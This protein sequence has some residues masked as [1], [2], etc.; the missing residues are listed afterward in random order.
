M[1][2]LYE[3]EEEQG[4]G[5]GGEG[6]GQEGRDGGAGSNRRNCL[7]VMVLTFSTDARRFVSGAGGCAHGAVGWV[8]PGGARWQDAPLWPGGWTGV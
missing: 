6:P 4:R 8:Q 1:W 7:G 3:E 2:V 5:S